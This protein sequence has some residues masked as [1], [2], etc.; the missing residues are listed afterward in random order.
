MRIVAGFCVAMLALLA[1]A[2][3]RQ[4]QPLFK[5]LELDSGGGVETVEL[6]RPFKVRSVNGT[7]F[8]GQRERLSG[9]LFELQATDGHEYSTKTDDRGNFRIVDVPPGTY[10][11]K[12]S[13]DGF[14]PTIGKVIVSRR[15]AKEARIAVKLELAT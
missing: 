12:V 5:A 4:A 8:Y 9:A 13:H 6:A 11:F 1:A 2:H 15:A 14:D 7:I 3:D 10:K